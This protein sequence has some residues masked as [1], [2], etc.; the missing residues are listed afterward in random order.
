[1][2]TDYALVPDVKTDR[3]GKSYPYFSPTDIS[4]LTQCPLARRHRH[5]LRVMSYHSEVGSDVHW[6]ELHYDDKM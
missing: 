5:A 6:Y 3:G 4:T 2:K 1:M